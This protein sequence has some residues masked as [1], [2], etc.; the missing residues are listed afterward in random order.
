V[1]TGTG[2]TLWRGSKCLF[3]DLAFSVGAGTALLVRGANGS[4]KTTL[5]RVIAGLTQPEH[6]EVR[7]RDEPLDRVAR[8]TG[9]VTLSYCGHAPALKPTM[10]TR[11]NLA[12]YA[13]LTGFDP[14]AIDAVVEDVGLSSCAMLPARV[15]SAGQKRRA[16]L[17][18]VLMSGAPLWLLDE[19]HT[20]LDTE[21]RHLLGQM[22]QRHLDG[23]GMAIIAAHEPLDLGDA[24][25]AMLN[26]GGY[27]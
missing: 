9:R 12:F 21:G 24:R 8:Q 15:L 4:G 5:L 20:N 26:L 23:T 7:W 2:L 16:S 19:P 1:L 17:A 18:R 10:T 3:E 22:L 13:A 11:E 27:E 6:G 14:A 25:T